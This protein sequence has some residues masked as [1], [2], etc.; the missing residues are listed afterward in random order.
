M[1]DQLSYGWY[2]TTDDRRVTKFDATMWYVING[3]LQREFLTNLSFMLGIDANARPVVRLVRM[4]DKSLS[5]ML[6]CCMSLMGLS[7]GNF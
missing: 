6:Q 3:T 1:Q 4:I 2:C 7:N 5:L